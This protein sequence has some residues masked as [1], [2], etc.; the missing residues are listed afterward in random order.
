MVKLKGYQI[1]GKISRKGRRHCII[2]MHMILAGLRNR[3]PSE[4]SFCVKVK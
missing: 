2:H 3:K 1:L 4:K